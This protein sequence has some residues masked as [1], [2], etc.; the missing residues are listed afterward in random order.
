MTTTGRT[1]ATR[2]GGIALA[3]VLAGCG[4]GGGASG[5][6]M[7]FATGGAL[8]VD[9][10][11]ALAAFGA[12][13]GPFAPAQATVTLS[14]A[15]TEGLA[16]SVELAGSWASVSRTSGVLLP[17]ESRALTVSV[18]SAADALPAG[19]HA[20][21]LLFRNDTDGSGTTI[22]GA[23]LFVGPTPDLVVAPLAS[24]DAVGAKGGAMVP[25]ETTYTLVNA[26]VAP[27]AW[28]ATR[29]AAWTTLGA[30]GGVL[31]PG[32]QASVAVRLDAAAVALLAPGRHTGGVAFTNETSGSGST[33]RAVALELVEAQEAFLAT[34]EEGLVASGPAGGPFEP[35]RADFALANLGGQALA[36]TAS[37]G[38][39]WV[40]LPAPSGLV[41]PGGQ[42]LV[43]IGIDPAAAAALP[44]GSYRDTVVLAGGGRTLART[45]DLTVTGVAAGLGVEPALGLAA[46]GS[47]GGP[48]APASIAYTLENRDAAPLAWTAATA[49]P[50]LALSS[51]GGTLAPGEQTA[52]LVSLDQMAAASLAP[53]AHQASVAIANETDG[54]GTTA[55]S[56]VLNVVSAGGS[57]AGALSQFGITWTFDR[58]YEVGRF[59]N[60][61]WW[62]VGPV[63]ILS[64][65]PPS[66]AGARERNGSMVNPDPRTQSQG[67]DSAMYGQY[68]WATSYEPERNAARGVS[69]AQPLVLPPHSSLVSTIG[70][71]TA[72]ARPQLAAAAVLTVLPAPAPPGSFRPPYCGADKSIAFHV[73]QLDR[74]KL[75]RLAPVASTPP[76]ATVEAW[77]ERPWIDHVPDWLGRYCHPAENMPDYGREMCD[78][79]GTAALMLHLDLPDAEKETLLVR[80][81]QLG[82]DLFGVVQAGGTGNWPAG[83][84]HHSGRK[85]PILF[86]GLLLGDAGMADIGLDARV[87]FNEDDQTFYVQETAPGVYNG[88]YGGYGPQHVGLPEWGNQHA[89]NLGQ[90]DATWFGNSYRTCC[91][92]NV[93]WG[94]VLAARIMG[95]RALWNHDALFDYLDRY[96]Q[97]APGTGQAAWTIGWTAFPLA[98]WD[99]YR[100]AF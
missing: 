62:V 86:A 5:G 95:A 80:F 33:E 14:N 2:P 77:F 74:A 22:R 85:W 48:F 75:A 47:A 52:L 82:I 90:D 50:W 79:V 73:G 99:A 39:A 19:A 25:R 37:A 20:A 32:Q 9:P 63:T 68:A 4:A 89:K 23:A 1:R 43:S 88:G 83:G 70:R 29:S 76:L 67:Y 57:S 97:V 30:S 41:A 24:F 12:P 69:P 100:D 44:P 36:W 54:A 93:W 66:V 60:G 72:G 28:S 6:T 65:D 40:E 11:G 16:W 46:S 8:V 15:G 87:A 53:G 81:V 3:L 21:S 98:M 71:N 18:T 34:P 64:I 49:S 27:L 84:G 51:T 94:E 26:G 61:D 45:V 13:G 58:P 91:T 92:A 10:P 59:A 38:T 17:G 96:R 55:R 31:D 42:T 56:V 35:E 7:S 78:E